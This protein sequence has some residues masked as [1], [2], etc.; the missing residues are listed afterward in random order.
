MPLFTQC[1]NGQVTQTMELFTPEF[2]FEDGIYINIAQLRSNSPVPKSD[3]LIAED[4]N[5]LAF[6][7]KILLVDRIKYYDAEGK[8]SEIER[9]M[10]LGFSA[11]G[12]LN[13]MH[14]GDFSS[15][16]M[17]GAISF[18]RADR[19]LKF[20]D[21]SSGDDSG[22][23]PGSVRYYSGPQPEQPPVRKKYGSSDCYLLEFSSGKILRFTVPNLRKLLADE[24][25]LYNEYVSLSRRSKKAQMF[26]FIG[27]FNGKNPLYLPVK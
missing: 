19:S 10:V 25:M 27:K 22:P 3:L 12:M 11:G 17:I 5:N 16:V 4:Y 18:F 9:N 7:R 8:H 23:L 2:R 21:Y 26:Y 13:L 6:F 24:K 15:E 14:K 20:P 1:L